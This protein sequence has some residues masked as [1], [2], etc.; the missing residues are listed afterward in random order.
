VNCRPWSY[1]HYIAFTCL[2]YSHCLL[3]SYTITILHSIC[4]YP[5]F[6]ANRWDWQPHRK[7]EIKYLVVLCAG[8]MLQLAKQSLDEAPYRLFWAV[9]SQQASPSVVCLLLSWTINLGFLTE[10]KP[11]CYTHHTFLLGFPTGWWKDNTPASIKNFFWCRCRGGRRRLLW[12]EFSHA[13]PLLCFKFCF[14]LFI[15]TCLVLSKT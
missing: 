2:F 4:S 8:S 12:G 11:C 13:H 10:G 14:T 7:L 6:Q 15:F 1:F 9:A 5:L 3:Y